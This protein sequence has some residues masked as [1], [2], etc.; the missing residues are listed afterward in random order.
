MT[1]DGADRNGGP[2]Q[3][4][5][6]SHRGH[7]NGPMVAAGAMVGAAMVF[8]CY[9]LVQFVAG[10]EPAR[11]HPTGAAAT[12]AHEPTQPIDLPL[13]PEEDGAP[14][15]GGPAE[16]VPH[17]LPE[18]SGSE[19]GSPGAPEAPITY[20]IRWGDTLTAISEDTGVPI[21]RL[22]EANGIQDPDLIYAGASLLIPPAA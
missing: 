15:P 10:E 9:G 17:G 2:A 1:D 13:V 7:G 18:V 3:R 12:G 11:A 6:V 5:R 19:Q 16:P 8:A 20:V 14:D 22:V 21:A 4:A